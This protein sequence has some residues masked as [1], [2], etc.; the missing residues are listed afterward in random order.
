LSSIFIGSG[1]SAGGALYFYFIPARA[2]L[3]QNGAYRAQQTLI[4][5]DKTGKMIHN[6]NS[7]NKGESFYA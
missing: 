6:I 3:T 1:R 7:K 4:V 2:A 5:L